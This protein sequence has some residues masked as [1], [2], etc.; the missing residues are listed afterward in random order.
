[1]IAYCGLDCKKCEAYIATQSNDGRQISR[2]AEKWSVKFQVEIEPVHI[3][4]DG[5]KAEGKKSFYC[6]S[7]CQ[8]RKCC[9]SKKYATCNECSNFPCSDLVIIL[10]NAPAEIKTG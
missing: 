9:I 1:M 7:L 10:H 4:C 3:L 6:V 2:V 8:V 5:C